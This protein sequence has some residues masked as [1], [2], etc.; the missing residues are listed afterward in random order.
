MN[1]YLIA[2]PHFSHANIIKYEKRPF[3]DTEDMDNSIIM[4]WNNLV[5]ENDLIFVL[6]DVFFCKSDRQRYIAS[7]LKGRKILIRG[8]HDRGISDTKFKKLG[9]D[10]H[11]YYFY[12]GYLLT[13]YPQ[14]LE[15]M[16]RIME[17]YGVKG[18]IHGHVHS[19]INDLDQ[20]FYRCVSVECTDYHPVWF[21]KSNGFR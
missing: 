17:E 15:G 8:N 20:N 13:H 14:P 4:Y 2:D 12:E 1:T 6:G 10:V 16:K 5:D 18:N 9:F 3:V 19:E 21:H 7:R 11:N